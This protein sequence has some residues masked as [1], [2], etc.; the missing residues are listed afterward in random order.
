MCAA[1]LAAGVLEEGE[2]KLLLDGPA[3][4]AGELE[5]R[6]LRLPEGDEDV[7][8]A[9]ERLTELVGPAGASSTPAAAATTRSLPTFTCGSSRPAPTPSR[10]WPG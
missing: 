5:T 3:Q 2:G 9:V 10:P 1:S 4:V 8:S 6:K 7:H